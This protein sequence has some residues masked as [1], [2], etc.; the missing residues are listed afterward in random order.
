MTH[1][2][3]Q[4]VHLAGVESGGNQHWFAWKGYAGRLDGNKEKDGKV[5]PVVQQIGQGRGRKR[6]D[7]PSV[8]GEKLHRIVAVSGHSAALA[9]ILRPAR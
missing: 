8:L 6:H 3:Q 4:V 1:G 9:L 7:D 2:D 5:A